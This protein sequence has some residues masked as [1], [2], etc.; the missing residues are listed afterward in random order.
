MRKVFKILLGV[1]FFLIAA[2][3]VIP[4]L[5]EDK[6]IDLV[7]KSAND[8]LNATFDFKEADLIVFRSF[9]NAGIELNEVT[10]INKFPFEGDTLFRAQAIELQLPIKQ[11]FKNA[12]SLSLTNFVISGANLD[13]HIDSSGNANYDIAKEQSTTKPD[14]PSHSDSFQLDL[15]SYEIVGSEITYKDDL[16]KIDLNLK[17]FNHSGTGN[18]STEK[19]E[20]KT[21]TKAQAVLSYDE[22]KYLSN[23]HIALDAILGIDFTE[24][25]YT[26]LEN[27][28]LINQLALVFEGFVKLNEDN[29]EIDVEFRTPSSDF[30]NF[31]A[32]IPEVYSQS[33][34]G[35]TTT[36]NF[37]VSGTIKGIVDENHIPQFKLLINSSD[38]SFKY[39]DLPK[40][41]ENIQINTEVGNKSGLTKDTY[42]AIDTLSFKIDEDVFN[43][44]ALLSELTGNMNVAAKLQGQINLGN[45]EK[46]HPAESL[47]DLKGKL[48]INANADFDMLSI[49][50]KQ[51]QNTRVTGVFSL[52]DFTYV[53]AEFG[54]PLQISTAKVTFQPKSV[55]LNDFRALIGNTDV[56]LRGNIDNLLGFFF[57]GENMQGAFGLAS[58]KFVVNDFKSSNPKD[59]LSI[60]G[61]PSPQKIKI[62][63]FL[64][65]TIKAEAKTVLYDNITL[66]NVSGTL[67]VRDQKAV[68]QE[69]T[70]SVFD[71]IISFDGSIDTKEFVPTF[72]MGLK[73]N[74]INVAESFEALNLFQALAPIA[75]A[76]DGR[77]NATLNMAGN[78]NENLSPD[79]NSLDGAVTS[80]LI[81][82]NLA[83]EK[84]PALQ[85]LE[86]NLS[87]FNSK[88]LNLDNLKV[89]FQFEDGKVAIKPFT[90]KYQDVKLD[91]SGGHGFDKTMDYT[92]KIYVPAKYLGKDASQLIARFSEQEKANIVIP[93]NAFIT[94]SF[95]A[96]VVTTDLQEAVTVL[97][98]QLAEKQKDKLVEQGAE[99]ISK[100]IND[101]LEKNGKAKDSTVADTLNTKN[102]GTEAVVKDV[103]NSIFSKKKKT[104]DSVN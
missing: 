61:N 28:M 52:S 102:N 97:A 84:I 46:V 72:E 101:Y 33:L 54:K 43:A 53:G 80:Q 22:V 50:E 65:A 49:E 25:T 88:E 51:Y 98:K 12:S 99:K 87:L 19:L 82:S 69:M 93:V 70:S 20:L 3:L 36:G 57:N 23:N 30:K 81:S 41:I 103:L 83:T 27:T 74:K 4:I 21:K 100:S 63:S 67:L 40:T 15:A 77:L 47:K 85:L 5:F 44:S 75:T 91:V 7:K 8:N 16:S 55:K 76:I 58:N 95:K 14:K 45:L 6:I 86:Q 37:D 90:F 96:P 32:L 39:P 59:S 79:L 78:L 38:A 2:I 13:I 11:L 89:N 17:D 104:S 1:L 64:N 92:A 18:L 34:D 24:N 35:V 62:P 66:K 31:L 56:S 9:P 48:F 60:T 26:F 10:L 29:Q 68:L 94:G 42:V 71:G 73:F